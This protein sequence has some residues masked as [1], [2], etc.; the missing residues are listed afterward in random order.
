MR[1]RSQ[2]WRTTLSAAVAAGLVTSGALVAPATAGPATAE[3][4]P[5]GAAATSGEASQ[6]PPPGPRLRQALR[7][8]V[9]AGAVA[10]TFE[11]VDLGD[12]SGGSAGSARLAP[13][14][15]ASDQARFR[16]ASVTKQLTAVLALQQVQ[17]GRWTL[18]TT[19]GDVLPGL[20]PARSDVT[21]GE[22][23]S[24]RSGVPDYLAAL[25]ADATTNAKFLA[26]ISPRRT[27]RELVGVAQQLPWLFE[28]G[29]SFGYSN[30]GYVI[31]GLMLRRATGRSLTALAQQ[32]I[33]RPAR[34][35][36][37]TWAAGRR[38]PA[39]RLREYAD[40]GGRRP[41]DLGS[42]NP[43]MFSAAG[44]LLTT[45]RD[46]NRFQVALS[47]GRLLA[48]RLVDTMRST[49]TRAD[50]PAGIGVAYGYGSYRIPDPCRPGRWLF[51]HDGASFGTHTL[52]FSSRDG[53]RRVTAALTGRQYADPEQPAYVALNRLLGAAF[54]STCRGPVAAPVPSARPAP[55]T[56]GLLPGPPLAPAR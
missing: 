21:L 6:A 37:S 40:L 39:P 45:T 26:A 12:R 44:A 47:R 36:E 27:D 31:V 18:G 56:D 46:L 50:D 3:P 24:H 52:S 35:S 23:L 10:A 7:R 32:R 15:A 4:A 29:T 30:T 16:A 54:A 38:M 42:F 25:V 17:R 11:V 49:V 20:W 1:R 22:L 33:L 55:T 8:V 19:I 2:C 51:G 13:R 53:R 43:T 14:R 48:P 9:R 41:L 34:M 28:P 5:R